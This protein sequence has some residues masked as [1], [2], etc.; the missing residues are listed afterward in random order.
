MG[1][2]AWGRGNLLLHVR[3]TQREARTMAT[4][5]RKRERGIYWAS[6]HCLSHV[7]NPVSTAALWL[8][9]TSLRLHISTADGKYDA[10]VLPQ[11]VPHIIE[12]GNSSIEV[13]R[14]MLT[15]TEDGLEANYTMWLRS[16]P[17]SPVTIS[18]HADDACYFNPH[19][20]LHGS[21][22]TCNTT[23]DT[24][25]GFSPVAKLVFTKNDWELPQLVTVHGVD[26]HLDEDDLH[27]HTLWAEPQSND[28]V[29][30][31][32]PIRNVSVILS[33]NDASQISLSKTQ[34]MTF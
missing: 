4:G 9:K 7:E 3:A 14:T 2:A 27:L 23:I 15:V 32:K 8:C 20:S 6:P 1:N 5:R 19:P 22:P 21:A 11:V 29:Y 30:I 28:L 10:A 31:T 33:D 18:I 16:E 17:W 26:D 34:G 24:G 13:S 25:S 12:N